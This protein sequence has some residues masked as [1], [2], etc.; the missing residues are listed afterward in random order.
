LALAGAVL[1]KL[2]PAVLLPAVYRRREWRMPVAFAAAV[3]V[4]YLPFLGAGWGVLGFLPAYA[5]EEGFIG[6][7]S[8]FY[9][10]SLLRTWPPIAGWPALVYVAGA[11]AIL[12][13]AAVAVA[14]ARKADEDFAGAALLAGLFM[15]LLSPHYPWY[16]AWLIVFACFA[17]WLS[18]LWLTNSAFLLYLV[19]VGSP[20][21]REGYRL[22]IESAIYGLFAVLALFDVWRRR[23][24]AVRSS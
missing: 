4:G 14:F 18:L 9:L 2:Y 23:R 17:P 20:L 10:W 15:F 8:G 5:K 1:V 22:P 12:A 19:Q 24:R 6:G 21:L 16:F 3:V 13:L 7:G 11:A